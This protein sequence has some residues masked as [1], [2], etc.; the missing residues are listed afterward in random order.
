MVSPWDYLLNGSFIRAAYEV[1][2][3]AF[4]FSGTQDYPIGILFIVFQILLFIQSRNIAF[5]FVVSLFL[6]A[7]LFTWIPTI[8]KGIIVTLLILELAG[9]IYVW[10]TKEN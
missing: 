1:Y 3:Q 5:H 7:A 10:A 2:N 6:F 9:I 4:A 8:I